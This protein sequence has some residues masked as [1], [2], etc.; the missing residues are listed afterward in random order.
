VAVNVPQLYTQFW[1]CELTTQLLAD[2]HP[3]SWL[4]FGWHAP[5]LESHVGFATHR[6][7]ADEVT[8]EHLVLHC[9]VVVSHWQ[10]E[11][12]PHRLGVGFA[13]RHEAVHAVPVHSHASVASHCGCDGR[14]PHACV[15]LPDSAFHV[16][17][18]S[19]RLHWIVASNWHWYEHWP[20]ETSM[21]ETMFAS[22]SYKVLYAMPS[23]LMYAVRLCSPCSQY[24]LNLPCWGKGEPACHTVTDSTVE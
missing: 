1:V 5:L 22:K 12:A 18:E 17:S 11:L 24:A 21:K 14:C 19:A 16:H 3:G 9:S 2:G 6:D 13:V 23:M 10:R 4:H 7:G 20:D 8:A 15:H